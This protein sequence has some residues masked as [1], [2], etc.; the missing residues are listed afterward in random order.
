MHGRLP[1]LV[2][3]GGRILYR[4][5]YTDAG[6]PDGAIRFT[7]PRTVAEWESYIRQIYQAGEDVQEYF[8]RR[9]A[10]LP[11]PTPV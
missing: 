10:H 5:L 1:E 3:I 2:V 9:V 7:D 11:A 6:V 8:R 4:V